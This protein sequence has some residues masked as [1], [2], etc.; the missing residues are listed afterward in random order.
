MMRIKAGFDPR[1]K[2]GNWVYVNNLW[3]RQYGVYKMVNVGADDAENT[4]SD[5]LV[6]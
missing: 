4:E 1:K 6:V 3:Y 5:V 2:S